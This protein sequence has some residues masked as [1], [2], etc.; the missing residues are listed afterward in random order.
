MNKKDHKFKSKSRNFEGL[1]SEYF[2][3]KEPSVRIHSKD[4]AIFQV[5]KV[6][7]YESKIKFY[8]V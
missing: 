1:F 6:R 2:K 7:Y 5:H 4:G 3:N 8:K